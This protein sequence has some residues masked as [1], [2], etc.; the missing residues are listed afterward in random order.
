MN[1]WWHVTLYVNSRGLTTGPMPYPAGVAEIQFDFEKHELVVLTSE[2]GSAS[3]PLRPESVAAFY[4]GVFRTLDHLGI[5]AEINLRPQEVADAVP[6]DRD[7]AHCSYDPE[8]GNRFWRI[9]VSSA[10]VLERFRATFTGKCSPVHF[11]WGS[12]DLACTRFSGRPA[13]PRKGV[14]SGPA[15]SCEVCSA[16]FWPGGGVIDGAAYYAYIVPQPAGIEN[17][18]IRPA[19]AHWNPQLSEFILMYDDVRRAANPEESL[20]EFLESTYDVGA[21]LANWDRASLEL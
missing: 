2:G 13:P 15:Y 1:H 11:F 5:T 19:A 8:Y 10:K 21:R 18:A 3:R 6:F 9:L 14:I 16:G 17:Q 12:F 7:T 20:Y 4:Q